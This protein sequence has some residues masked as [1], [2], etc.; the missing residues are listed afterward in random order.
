MALPRVLGCC[1]AIPESNPAI[2]QHVIS[3][4]E[5]CYNLLCQENS[6]PTE[7]LPP[8]PKYPPGCAHQLPTQMLTPKA[9]APP[10]FSA[11]GT[12]AQATCAPS[13]NISLKTRLFR[14]KMYQPSLRFTIRSRGYQ[15]YG[16]IKLNPIYINTALRSK[17]KATFAC[18]MELEEQLLTSPSPYLKEF[19]AWIA[20][21][22]RQINACIYVA[23]SPR[24]ILRAG[25]ILKQGTRGHLQ[26]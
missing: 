6:N 25:E 13:S 12:T 9:D 17:K 21:A 4:T 23:A 2:F 8:P 22:P 14:G 24:G 1:K 10:Q 18:T 3:K 16:G 19:G 20:S 11:A 7:P 15:H 5:I 26:L